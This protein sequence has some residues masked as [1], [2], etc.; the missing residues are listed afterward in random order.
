MIGEA[1]R[2]LRGE[3]ELTQEQLAFDLNVSKQM[4]SHMETGR[5]KMQKDI[6]K[7]ALSTY[8]VPE[9][10]IELIYE[11][12][13]GYTSP[14]FN[15]KAIERHRL[16]LEEFAIRESKEAIRILEEVSFIKPPGETTSDERER[17][18]RVIDELIDAEAAINNLKAI[19]AKEYKI[20]LKKRYDLRKPYWKAKGWI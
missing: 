2:H 12:S 9:V 20:S 1:L 13:G 10:A 6:A 7:A 19:L 11:F 3:E 16:A 5:R 18:G 17:V 14:L 8:D 4:V 15:G